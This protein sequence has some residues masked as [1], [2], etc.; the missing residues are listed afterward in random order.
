MYRRAL[1]TVWPHLT[2][3]NDVKPLSHC[4]DLDEDLRSFCLSCFH[5]VLND[6]ALI[7]RPWEGIHKSRPN[8]ALHFEFLYMHKEKLWSLVLYKY[9]LLI[10][11]GFLIC[12][13]EFLL[14]LRM[15]LS[16]PLV[17]SYSIWSSYNSCQWTRIS[18]QGQS[19]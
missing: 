1:W 15:I 19:D 2:R 10:K 11:D 4:K 16:F 3:S 5:C 12:L 6:I 7:C 13:N 14:L 9:V 8:K 17:N 18:F